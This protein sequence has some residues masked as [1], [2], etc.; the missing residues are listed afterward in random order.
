MHILVITRSAWRNDSNTGNTLS[1]LFSGVD[2]E[3]FGLCFRDEKPENNL[4]KSNFA[5]TESQIIANLKNKK[6]VVGKE[7][8]VSLEASNRENDIYSAAKNAGAVYSVI[9]KFAREILWSFGTY[10]TKALTQYI[11]KVNP[12]IIFMPVFNC[13]YPHKVLRYIHTL[14]DAKIILF[15]ADDNYS[16]KKFSFNPLYWLYRFGLRRN[17]KKSVSISDKNYV[18]SALQK[19]EYE[20]AFKRE[21]QILTKSADFDNNMNFEKEENEP[22]ELVYT[23]NLSVGRWKTLALINDALKNINKDKKV[24]VMKVYSYSKLKA[25]QMNT[26]ADGENTFF[27]GGVKPEMIAGIQRNADILVYS[28]S[29]S[30]KEKLEVRQSFSTKIVDYLCSGNPIFAVGPCGIASINYFLENDSAKVATSESEIEA[31]LKE[32]IDKKEIRKEYAQKAYEC[33]KKNHNAAV[34]KNEFNKDLKSVLL[35]KDNSS[36]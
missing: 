13:Y 22:L 4:M 15:H 34:L 26:L 29:F 19:S 32:I 8:C 18:I 20:E 3:F 16:L 30:L 28:E 33:G 23:G 6:N 14:T 2:A 9:L 1:D 12:D 10:K 25:E 7:N 11:K 21:C 35:E 5:I 31:K 17:I 36:L 27:M 24:A